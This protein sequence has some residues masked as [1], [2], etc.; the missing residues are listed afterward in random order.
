VHWS[1][2]QGD[3]RASTEDRPVAHHRG[4]PADPVRCP[5]CAAGA[6]PNPG[7]PTARLRDVLRPHENDHARRLRTY[8]GT[9]KRAFDITGCGQAAVQEKLQEMHD[10]EATDRAAKADALSA[11]IDP[12]TREINLGCD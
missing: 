12:F 8:D 9:T 3:R 6:R 4:T 1:R 10:T 5:D 7:G 11:A 2:R